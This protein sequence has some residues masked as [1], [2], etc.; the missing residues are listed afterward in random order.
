[1]VGTGHRSLQLMFILKAPNVHSRRFLATKEADDFHASFF[2]TLIPLPRPRG[3]CCLCPQTGIKTLPEVSTWG[4]S[5]RFREGPAVPP[6][7]L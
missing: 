2:P 4:V 6:W 5:R 1:M 3:L 7:H